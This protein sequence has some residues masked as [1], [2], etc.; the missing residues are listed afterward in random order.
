LDLR[1]ALELTFIQQVSTLLLVIVLI[2]VIDSIIIVPP[3]SSSTSTSLLAQFCEQCTI[4]TTATSIFSFKRHATITQPITQ[5]FVEAT[6][7]PP[8]P[9]IQPPSCIFAFLE[10]IALFVTI[11]FIDIIFGAAAFPSARLSSLSAALP[12]FPTTRS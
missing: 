6:T 7:L 2:V 11:V 4:T 5:C 3:S 12:L 1:L 9:T 10:I 8:S